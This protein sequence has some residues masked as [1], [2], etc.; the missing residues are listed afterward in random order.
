MR[1]RKWLAAGLL[2]VAAAGGFYFYHNR[3]IGV[4]DAINPAYWVRRWKGEDLYDPATDRLF[5]GNRSLKEVAITIDDG[6]HSGTGDQLLDI[7]KRENARATFFVVG[8]NMKRRPDLVKRMV[9]EGHEVANHT[10]THYRL[11][12]LRPDQMRR[13]INDNDI[14]FYRITGRHMD[15]LRPP[16]VNYNATVSKVAME[17]G[18]QTI[19]VNVLS[20]DFD[21][22]T[23][24][25]IVDATLRRTENGS[26]I[27]L[28]DDRMSTVMAL[29][30]II[31]GLRAEGYKFVT[32][33]EM[34]AHLPKPVLVATNADPIGGRRLV[35]NNPTNRR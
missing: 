30:R 18:Y 26:I 15:L 17:L 6:P 3:K 1:K 29:P 5:H 8:I 20:K 19:L 2:A 28:H 13:E 7:L 9:E 27:L 34:L 11:S 35:A 25:F 21:D 31:D 14:N 23:P 4:M 32:V 24:D 16:G 33:S 22:Q 12:K 10:F